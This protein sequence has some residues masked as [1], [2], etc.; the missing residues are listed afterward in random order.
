MKKGLRKLA[1]MALTATMVMSAGMPAFANLPAEKNV[2]DYTL[3]EIQGWVVEYFAKEEIPMQLG[4]DEYYDYVVN[5]LISGTDEKLKQHPQYDLIHAYMTE[6]K[7]E[8]DKAYM[9]DEMVSATAEL[10]TAEEAVFYDEKDFLGQTIGEIK[11]SVEKQ[12]DVAIPLAVN[13]TYSYNGTAAANYALQYAVIA[14]NDYP[15]Y[16]RGDCTNFV[17]QCLVAG[18]MSMTGTPSDYGVTSST[19]LWHCKPFYLSDGYVTFGATTAWTLVTDF[20]TYMERIGADTTEYSSIA[21]VARNCAVGDIVQLTDKTTGK[22]HHSIIISS[23]SSTDFGYCG[24]TKAREDDSA[25]QNIDMT[26]NNLLL[27]K[28]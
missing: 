12:N 26:S 13:A 7:L 16:G 6:Y 28:D 19:T 21:S 23:K 5:Q 14:N 17:S 24:H 15:Y 10:S 27:Y 1:A 20:R 8:C 4:T 2:D 11:E 9:M 22:P 25:L 18:G 3:G